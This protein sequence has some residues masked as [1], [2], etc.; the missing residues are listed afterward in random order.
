MKID[1]RPDFAKR[2][3]EARIKRGFSTAKEASNFFGWRYYS[4]I[5]H[6]KG[7]RGIGRVADR[8]AK[9]FKVSSAWLLTGEGES[10]S[11][12]IEII[13]S[14]G[15]GQK[16]F[17]INDGGD[18]IEVPKISTDMK[19]ATVRGDSMLPAYP[20]GSTVLFSRQMQPKE[21]INKLCVVYLEDDSAYLKTIKAG[22]K[23]NLYNLISSNASDIL[24]VD[25]K[26]A[27]PVEWVKL[28]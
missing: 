19:A 11:N 18:F 9:A 17:P 3:E 6:E 15:A 8:Y 12:Q 23:P 16:I 4:Y 22:T 5:Q 7:I 24:N 2:L 20:D 27:A 25:I 28:K 14:V 26:W 10:P 21:A 13:G 1:D